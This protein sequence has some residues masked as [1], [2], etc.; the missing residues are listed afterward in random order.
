MR[1]LKP[2]VVQTDYPCHCYEPSSMVYGIVVRATQTLMIFSCRSVA[3]SRSIEYLRE[4]IERGVLLNGLAKHINLKGTAADYFRCVYVCTHEVYVQL[5]NTYLGHII[6][7]TL[8]PRMKE[9][10]IR[11]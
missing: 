9:V 1:A 8:M 4:V 2:P 11:G 3:P 7:E 5:K 6:S 10:R